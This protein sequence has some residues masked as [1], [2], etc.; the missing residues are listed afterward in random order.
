MGKSWT[1]TRVEVGRRS[2]VFFCFFGV[3]QFV[4]YARFQTPKPREV[5]IWTTKTYPKK[6]NLSIASNGRLGMLTLKYLHCE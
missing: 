5:C 2:V 6:T 1:L 3:A 4:Y